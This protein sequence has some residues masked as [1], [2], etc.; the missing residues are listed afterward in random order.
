MTTPPAKAQ[1]SGG[2]KLTVLYGPPK[3]LAAFEAHYQ[4]KHIPLVAAVR[5]IRRIETAQG[6]AL[7]DGS[8]PAF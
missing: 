5:G 7:P 4:A 1:G 2:V 8:P 6:V 3:D